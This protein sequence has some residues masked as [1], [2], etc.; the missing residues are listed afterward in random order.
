[1]QTNNKYSRAM[2]DGFMVKPSQ[3]QAIRTRSITP[4]R[5]PQAVRN[6]PTSGFCLAIIAIFVFLLLPAFVR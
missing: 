1:M 5:K 6:K 4:K 3:P 2:R